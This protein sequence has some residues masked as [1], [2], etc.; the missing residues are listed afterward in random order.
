MPGP[1]PH[2]PVPPPPVTGAEASSASQQTT[3]Y[4]A[5]AV[6]ADD[7]R[8]PAIPGYEIVGVLGHGGMGVVYLARQLSLNR[9][10]ALKVVLGGGHA[11]GAERVRFMQ[12]AEAVAALNHP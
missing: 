5:R 11:P 6:D 10:V 12:E 8:P 9:T 4:H 3:P 2:D 1:D 7:V